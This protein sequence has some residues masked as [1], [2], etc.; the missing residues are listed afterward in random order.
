MTN[1][2]GWPRGG[3]N[4]GVIAWG[5][6]EAQRAEAC[7]PRALDGGRDGFLSKLMGSQEQF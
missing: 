2:V 1:A 4:N 6:L 3:E 7:V 5:L